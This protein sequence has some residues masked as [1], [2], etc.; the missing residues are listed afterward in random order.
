MKWLDR[1]WNSSLD[2]HVKNT[3]VGTHSLAINQQKLEVDHL[4]PSIAE[5]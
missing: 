3:S 2:Y 4:P 5:M 1:G